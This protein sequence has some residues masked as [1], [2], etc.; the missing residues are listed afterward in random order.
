MAT[1]IWVTPK[2]KPQANER[3]YVLR[4]QD[5]DCWYGYYAGDPQTVR[6]LRKADWTFERITYSRDGG[7]S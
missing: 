5:A 4:G 6:A 2:D 7:G 3:A 1:L